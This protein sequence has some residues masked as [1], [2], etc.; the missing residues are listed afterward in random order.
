LTRNINAGGQYE[1]KKGME[2]EV[3]F[4]VSDESTLSNLKATVNYEFNEEYQF[5]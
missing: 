4:K 2:W 1:S 5:L 3:L